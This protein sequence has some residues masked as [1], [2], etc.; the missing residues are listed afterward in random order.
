[1]GKQPRTAEQLRAMVQ[2]R[3]DDLAEVKRRTSEGQPVPAIGLPQ[4]TPYDRT[5]RTWDMATPEH[6]TGLVISFRSIVD[7]L[8]EA[9]DLA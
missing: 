1:M 3:V 5:G 9:Y 2:L 6:C 8:R 4:R 7:A